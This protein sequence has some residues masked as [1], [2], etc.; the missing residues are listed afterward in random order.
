M[1]VND[2]TVYHRYDIQCYAIFYFNNMTN[3]KWSTMLTAIALL[4]NEVWACAIMDQKIYGYF[5]KVIFVFTFGPNGNRNSELILYINYLVKSLKLVNFP[6]PV[7]CLCTARDKD[8][9]VYWISLSM[10]KVLLMPLVHS[11]FTSSST[12]RSLPLPMFAGWY[13]IT[14]IFLFAMVL[15]HFSSWYFLSS[16]P[17]MQYAI[18]R[19]ASSSVQLSDTELPSSTKNPYSKN[20]RNGWY[21]VNFLNTFIVWQSVWLASLIQFNYQQA[22]HSL[23]ISRLTIRSYPTYIIELIY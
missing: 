6:I 5:E 17:A 22:K 21:L 23:D 11:I 2:N 1:K 16:S 3:A 18:H 9:S 20:L 13:I 12:A 4:F 15:W 19:Q 7:P 10:I 8:K 14:E